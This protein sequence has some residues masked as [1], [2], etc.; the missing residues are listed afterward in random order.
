MITRADGY[1]PHFVLRAI[2]EVR[3]WSPADYNFR[4]ELTA[5][6]DGTPFPS[7]SRSLEEGRSI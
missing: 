1:E 2:Q 4:P 3:G 7:E 5:L 6:E